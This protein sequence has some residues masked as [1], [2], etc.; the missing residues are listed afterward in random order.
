MS[1]RQRNQIFSDCEAKWA[2][3]HRPEIRKRKTGR[4]GGRPLAERC[5]IT[6][7]SEPLL[8]VSVDLFQRIADFQ[9]S[10]LNRA[11]QCAKHP[12]R[13]SVGISFC[14]LFL[15]ACSVKEKAGNE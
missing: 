7:L 11:P 6:S 15:C 3:G 12:F 10:A 5:N 8:K 2:V 14:E 1:E 13:V 9:G 4:P